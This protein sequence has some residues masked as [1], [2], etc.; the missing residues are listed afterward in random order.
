MISHTIRGDILLIN[1]KHVKPS[2]KVYIH[3][4]VKQQYKEI[5]GKVEQVKKFGVPVKDPRSYKFLT[6]FQLDFWM[7]QVFTFRIR[8]GN[9]QNLG[10]SR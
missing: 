5:I 9:L 6:W 3:E 2:N 10:V 1:A 7:Q 4:Y 8:F